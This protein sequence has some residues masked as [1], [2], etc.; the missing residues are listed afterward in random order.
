VLEGPSS[1]HFDPSVLSF[2]ILHLRLR[3][4]HHPALRC[5]CVWHRLH[6]SC[7]FGARTGIR[8]TG[9]VASAFRIPA[10]R[11]RGPETKN[12]LERRRTPHRIIVINCYQLLRNDSIIYQPGCQ[13]R[14]FVNPSA[15]ISAVGTYEISNL[16]FQ[17]VGSPFSTDSGIRPSVAYSP[18]GWC[19]KTT[20]ERKTGAPPQALYVAASTALGGSTNGDLE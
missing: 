4:Q 20:R 6:H 9:L 16:L 18:C 17:S 12:C 5:V 19:D 2:C 10:I 14:F 7:S 11:T 1:H 3:T 8:I 15:G 13:E